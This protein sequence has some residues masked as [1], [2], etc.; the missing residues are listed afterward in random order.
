[1]HSKSSTN[2]FVEHDQLSDDY[3]QQILDLNLRQLAPR[4]I[5]DNSFSQIFSAVRG[6][7]IVINNLPSSPT[8]TSSNFCDKILID[9][10]ST[11]ENSIELKLTISSK[12]FTIEKD[13]ISK[14]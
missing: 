5:K 6:D 9:I 12:T 2:D 11:G 1:M 7:R 10:T 13:L 4:A 3:H 8:H 14:D